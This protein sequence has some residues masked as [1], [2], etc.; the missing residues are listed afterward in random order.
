MDLSK[1][2][3]STSATSNSQYV[4]MLPPRSTTPILRKR[5]TIKPFN[6][7]VEG[8]IGSGKSEFLNYFSK[9]ANLCSIIP[10]PVEKWRN[11]H[12]INLMVCFVK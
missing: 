4:P 10:E 5:N 1:A 7:V 6:V 11:Y 12:G 9:Y 8:N 2:G 3:P